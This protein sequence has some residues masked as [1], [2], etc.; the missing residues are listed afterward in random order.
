M[1]Q[2]SLSDTGGYKGKIIWDAIELQALHRQPRLSVVLISVS[3]TY[4]L[5]HDQLPV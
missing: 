2:A 1:K 3:L 5:D 4:M